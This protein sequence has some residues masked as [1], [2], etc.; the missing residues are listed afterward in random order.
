M[1]CLACDFGGSSVKYALVDENANLEE[2]G[3]LPAPLKSKEQF[4]E[5]I[6]SLYS[7][8]KDHIEGI[9]LSMPGYINPETGYLYGSGVYRPL[10]GTNIIDLVHER[11][12]VNISI[13]ND[14]KCGALS[15]A[16]KGALA[17]CRDGAVL[18]LGS[19]VGGGIIKNKTVHWGKNFTAGELSYMITDSG[20]DQDM[21]FAY[22]SVGMLGITYKMCKYKNLDISVQDSC[23]MLRHLDEKLRR[24][25]LPEPAEKLAGIKADGK[26]FFTW[27]EQ[28]DKDAAKVY[29]EFLNNL[30]TMIHNIQV[31]YSPERIVIGGG[32]SRQERIFPDLNEKLDKLYKDAEFGEML[33]ADVVRSKYLEECNLL[34]AMY[35]YLEKYGQKSG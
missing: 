18:I 24:K 4:A 17:D 21:M 25:E 14:G 26:R 34:G 22:M 16:W 1:Q 28:G 13:E 29:D 11:C 15:E 12:P 2:C 35:N 19:A 32:I 5:T 27:L 8:Y 9:A 3:K 33:H 31:C 23:D 7:T 6:Y 20:A 10:Y 30:A